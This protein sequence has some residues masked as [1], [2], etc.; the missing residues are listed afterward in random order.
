MEQNRLFSDRWRL[1]S[2]YVGVM[3]FILGMWFGVYQQLS[4]PTGKP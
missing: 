4:M 2:W 3:G 1:A